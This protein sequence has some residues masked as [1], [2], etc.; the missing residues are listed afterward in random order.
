MFFLSFFLQYLMR[1]W[2]GDLCTKSLYDF[3]EEKGCFLF[4]NSHQKKSV[5]SLLLLFWRIRMEWNQIQEVE[6][7]EEECLIQ[8]KLIYFKKNSFVM[9][10]KKKNHHLNTWKEWPNFLWQYSL[11]FALMIWSTKTAFLTFEAALHYITSDKFHKWRCS[12][13]GFG[14]LHVGVQIVLKLELS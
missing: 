12:L 1:S 4:G 14:N 6:E 9:C 13:M 3:S 10:K 5:R 11:L 7:D 2:N 8:K